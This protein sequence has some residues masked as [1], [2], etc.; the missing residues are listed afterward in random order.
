MHISCSHTCP[1]EIGQGYENE[2]EN[3]RICS[4][5]EI[6][7]LLNEEEN[8]KFDTKNEKSQISILKKRK[9]NNYNLKNPTPPK[10]IRI[11]RETI[12]QLNCWTTLT[13]SN[14]INTNIFGINVCS[15]RNQ[16][17]HNIQMTIPCS[18][19]KRCLK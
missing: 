17:L 7:Y 5:N 16:E 18:A 1:C 2:N 10:V 4:L 12:W 3:E 11:V 8:Q 9:S 6:A 15:I 13:K 19:M 14:K